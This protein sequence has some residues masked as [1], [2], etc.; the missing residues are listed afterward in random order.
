MEA[1]QRRRKE[2]SLGMCRTRSFKLLY[3]DRETAKKIVG[4]TKE[5]DEDDLF[6]KKIF[7][8]IT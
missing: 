1:C 4:G 2:S 6:P 7:H 8:T 5:T 3:S